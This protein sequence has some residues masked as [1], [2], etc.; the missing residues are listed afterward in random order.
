MATVSRPILITALAATASGLGV[1]GLTAF[2]RWASAD[3]YP[4]SDQAILEIYTLH[5]VRGFWALGPYSQFGWHHPGP[6][7]FYLLAPFYALSGHKTIALHIGAFAINMLSLCGIVYLL[8]RNASAAVTCLAVLMMGFYLSRLEPVMTSYWNPHIV[9]LPS[10]LYLLLC[11]SVAA[12]HRSALPASI[13]VGAFLV[14][15]HISLA[16]YVV[17]LGCGALVAAIRSTIFSPP[18]DRSLRRTLIASLG[19]LL[20]LWLP[21]IVEQATHSPGN[22]TRVA[23][24][25]AAPSSGQ[26]LRTAMA[27]WGDMVCGVFRRQLDLP[28]GVPLQLEVESITSTG[29]GAIAQAL[30]LAALCLDAYRRQDSSS[31]ALTAAGL[32]ASLAALWSITR[33]QS[34]VGDYTIFWLSAVGALNWA[35]GGGVML[36]RLTGPRL[37]MLQRVAAL[38]ASALVIW[39]GIHLGID[40]LKR[41]RRQGLLRQRDSARV[42]QLAA[43]AILDDMQRA[44]AHR[45][46]FH[47][48]TA[49][50]TAAAGILLQVY[51]RGSPP[52]VDPDLVTWFGE[53]FARNGQEDRSFVITDAATQAR[54]RELPAGDSLPGVERL[55]IYAS[56]IVPPAR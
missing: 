34:L 18:S 4:V 37:R 44:H 1:A 51:K 29:L 56:P 8:I 22:I 39:L 3:L 38:G 15:T 19:V 6:L 31:C 23:R 24:F 30:L 48:S 47:L 43:A 11:A 10:A 5:A 32:L 45:P 33:V 36:A 40:Q 42:V 35:V 2:F 50:W 17:L 49:D 25:F 52:A 41:E 26:S 14:Q 46:L 27:V 12:G 9:I 53:P 28:E 7:Y 20:L 55:Y 21:P 13:A 54:L 16:P